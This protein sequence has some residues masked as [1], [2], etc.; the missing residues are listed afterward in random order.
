M[1][2]IRSYYE[3]TLSWRYLHCVKES[4][5]RVDLD[6]N[7]GDSVSAEHAEHALKIL[8]ESKEKV[9]AKQKKAQNESAPAK[10]AP[11]QVNVPKR[12]ETKAPKKDLKNEP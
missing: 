7:E 12:A 4:E 11:K 1:Y 3:Y 9:F 5:K 10:R 8:K 2:A 6:G